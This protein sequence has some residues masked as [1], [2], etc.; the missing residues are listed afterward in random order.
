MNDWVI[1]SGLALPSANGAIAGGVDKCRPKAAVCR[2][3]ALRQELV[4]LGH[5]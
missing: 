3:I 2:L 1:M 4:R 5:L